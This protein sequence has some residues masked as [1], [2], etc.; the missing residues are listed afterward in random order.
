M[1]SDWNKLHQRKLRKPSQSK[2]YSRSPQQLQRNDRNDGRGNVGRRHR[3]R[4]SRRHGGLHFDNFPEDF[5]FRG[6]PVEYSHHFDI[7]TRGEE[8][9]TVFE[10]THRLGVHSTHAHK[11]DTHSFATFVHTC[12]CHMGT[13]S[14]LGVGVLLAVWIHNR[15]IKG[16]VFHKAHKPWHTSVLQSVEVRERS[17]FCQDLCARPRVWG[18]CKTHTTVRWCWINT[19]VRWPN[20]FERSVNGIRKCVNHS[21]FSDIEPYVTKLC[22]NTPFALHNLT[23]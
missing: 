9:P 23:W 18:H 11:S 13:I 16:I 10:S 2:K 1:V 19:Y 17:T 12:V 21:S 3:R 6:L 4:N 7:T 15:S 20:R 5:R 8:Y 22:S 14:R